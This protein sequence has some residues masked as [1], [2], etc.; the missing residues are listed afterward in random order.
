[1]DSWHIISGRHVHSSVIDSTKQWDMDTS[2]FIGKMCL[3]IISCFVFMGA[4]PR[5]F[6]L[7]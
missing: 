6:A 2:N 3:E 1:M 4:Q 5:G 7:K